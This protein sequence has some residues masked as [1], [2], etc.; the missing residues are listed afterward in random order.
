MSRKP[1]LR[2]RAFTLIEL[3]IVV[4]IIAILAAIAVPNFLE[5]QVRAKVSRSRADLRSVATGLE[6]YRVDWNKYPPTPFVAG[7]VLRVIPNPLSSPVAYITSV[8]M[9]DPFIAANLGDFQ[10]FGNN[11]GV[12]YT[13]A[14][15]PALYWEPGYDPFAGRRYYYQLNR[16]DRRS[17]GAQAQLE[18]GIPVEGE[19][20]LASVGPNKRR[21]LSPAGMFANG[22]RV[23]IPY[24][25]TNGTISGGDVV[26]SQAESQGGLSRVQ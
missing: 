21:D 2:V 25:A 4:A 11:T 17:A 16:D 20:V 19:W 7:D 15:D 6:S 3:L 1:P 8:G 26:R 23:L 9:P 14:G 5:A 24:D 13:Y 10:A 22:M 12:L 18:A